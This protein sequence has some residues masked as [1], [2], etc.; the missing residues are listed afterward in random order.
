MNY[1]RQ[2]A[3]E[4]CRGYIGCAGSQIGTQ[5]CMR[6]MYVCGWC[7]CDSGC[8]CQKGWGIR[9]ISACMYVYRR[10]GQYAKEAQVMLLSRRDLYFL[11]WWGRLWREALGAQGQIN[12]NL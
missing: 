10:G 7:E 9:N 1:H 4:M 2:A 3:M 8:V 12:G 6:R 5:V 11:F